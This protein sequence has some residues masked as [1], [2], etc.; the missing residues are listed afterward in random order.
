MYFSV[1]IQQAGLYKFILI[2][3]KWNVIIP[4]TI[5]LQTKLIK[6]ADTE[7]LMSRIN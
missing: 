2:E 1:E 4:V 6:G 5:I 7:K 3:I